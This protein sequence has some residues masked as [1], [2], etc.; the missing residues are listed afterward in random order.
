MGIFDTFTGKPATDAAGANT[1][2]YKKYGTDSMGYLD[3]GMAGAMPQLDKAVDAYTPLSD[4]GAKYGTGTNAYMDALGINGAAGNA[5]AVGQ[6]QESPGYAYT[7]DQAI[8]ATARNANRFGAGGNEIAAVT[9]RASNLANQEWQSHLTNLGGF[10]NPEL[11]ATSGAAAGQAAGY[12]AKAGAYSTDATNRVGIAGNVASGI[13][14]SNTAAANSQ[15]QANSQFW[16]GLMKMGGSVAGAAIMASDRRLK[17]D[18]VRTGDDPRGFGQYSYRYVW[19]APHVRRHGYM[20]DEV[21]R[22]RPDAV[23]RSADGFAMIDYGVLE[24]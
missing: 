21:E 8:E 7:R 11:Q 10:M 16:N 23:L 2:E 4:L 1:A 6:F 15:M 14:N 3:A 19:D 12:G 17:L 18:I 5:R 22:V 9:D 20:A 13:A 24:G